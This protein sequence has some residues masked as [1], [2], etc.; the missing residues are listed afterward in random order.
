MAKKKT[1]RRPSTTIPLA[2]L[3]GF[4]PLT[5]STV[6]AFKTGGVEGA[7]R[8]ATASLTGYNTYSKTWEY[9]HM[10][11]GLFPIL[12]GLGAHKLASKLGVNR[13]LASAGVPFVRI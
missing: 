12:I 3:I 13:A 9:Q 7:V 8:V 10:W 6:S 2:A 5:I 11:N 4:A 1:H